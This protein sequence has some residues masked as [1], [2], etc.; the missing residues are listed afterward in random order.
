M[1]REEIADLS[2]DLKRKVMV[3]LA[4][5]DAAARRFVEHNDI[6]QKKFFASSLSL[7]YGRIAFFSISF[8][9]RHYFGTGQSRQ[10]L[11]QLKDL[12]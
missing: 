4:T 9:D 6:L 7:V 10:F 2:D 1:Y 3:T 5:V 12:S 11:T 8:P